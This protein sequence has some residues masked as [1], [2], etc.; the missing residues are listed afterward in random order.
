MAI[1]TPGNAHQIIFWMNS[2]WAK[3]LTNTQLDTW[4]ANGLDGLVFS[5][6]FLMGAGQQVGRVWTGNATNR[7]TLSQHDYQQSIHDTAIVSRCQ[8]RGIECYL[9]GYLANTSNSLTPMIEWFSDAS[10]T[11]TAIPAFTNFAAAA[12][13][14]GFDGIALDGEMYA[15]T[16][17]ATWERG[18]SGNT[19]GESATRAKVKERGASVMT[20]I[21]AQMPAAT[22][23]N[24]RSEFPGNWR[25]VAHQLNGNSALWT[26]S[27]M[28]NF[29]DG[30]SSVTT[31][32][33][34]YFF[35]EWFYKTLW[36]PPGA[37]TGWAARME[38]NY[39][40]YYGSIFPAWEAWA[41][42]Q[43]K[44]FV[45]PFIWIDN[46]S[47]SDEAALSTVNFEE[48]IEAAHDWGT[49]GKF[50]NFCFRNFPNSFT[51]PGWTN[52]LPGL[53]S[54][55][56]PDAS[57]H[58]TFPNG[59][60]VPAGA[61]SKVLDTPYIF[62]TGSTTPTGGLSSTVLC[63]AKVRKQLIRRKTFAPI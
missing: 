13:L 10:W 5:A 28:R 3:A 27:L 34:I 55:S 37:Q 20:A 19:Q 57:G 60:V 58:T 24:Y 4:K 8:A 26:D 41:T 14:E 1:P 9:G 23:I 53:L 17:G 7:D 21:L 48:Q 25:D 15:S 36:F 2:D 40:A 63:D 61:F 50:G 47:D 54:A 39:D 42:V 59:T 16:G 18:Y 22:I 35:D 30:M 62:P 33:A 51:S 38:D 6:G 11:S 12:Q 46:G 52:Y 49:G 44:L 29:W 32:E 45:S 43:S 31:F 56:T